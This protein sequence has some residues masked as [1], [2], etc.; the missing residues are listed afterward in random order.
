VHSK[1]HGHGH[2]NGGGRHGNPADL[3]A[4]IARL[5][6]PAR[7][8]WQKPDDVIAALGIA[9]GSVVAE[10]GGGSGYFAL[11]LAR[12]VG[13]AGAVF[14]VDVEPALLEVFRDRVRDSGARNVT[15]VLALPDDPLLPPA[16]CDRIVVVNT[17]H[18]FPDGP[19]YL[20]RLT[21]ALKPGGT[22]A[23]IDFHDRE[24]PVGPPIELRV[25]E[26]DFR[27]DVA[28][29]GLR[30]MAAPTFLPYQYFL[31]MTPA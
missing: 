30:V 26:E 12:A 16:S 1:S 11:R 29:A 15:P 21:R 18:H 5:E 8:A 4:Y 23:N 27:K 3:A 28:A 25:A 20:R 22:I 9:P 24:I 19:A 10:V 7:E 6:D 14:A 13:N 17:Y 31:V 2:G